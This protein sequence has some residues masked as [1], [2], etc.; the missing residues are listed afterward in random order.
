MA[1]DPRLLQFLLGRMI[2]QL[3]QL[4]KWPMWMEDQQ[5]GLTPGFVDNYDYWNA[6]KYGV[7]RGADG[8]M[9]S[10]VPQTGLLL[11]NPAHPTFWKTLRGEQ[12]GGYE[13]YTGQ[14]GRLYSRPAP[15][16]HWINQRGKK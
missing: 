13:V 7:R 4:P 8:H 15:P 6:N 1:T 10:R 12:A 11:K 14:D 5:R 9:A 3:K 2:P 16:G